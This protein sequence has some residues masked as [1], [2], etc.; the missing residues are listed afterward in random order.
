[1]GRW[2][3]LLL[4]C[5]CAD[6]DHPSTVKDLRVLALAAEPSEV[7]LDVAAGGAVPPIT[8]TALVVDPLGAGRPLGFAVRACANDPRAPTAPGTGSEASGNYPAGGAR[9]TVGS[10]RCPAESATSWTLPPAV[11]PGP[12]GF[13][14]TIQ[15]SAAQLR[16]AFETDLFLGPLGQPHGGFDLGLPITVELAVEA[17]T[18]RVV[19]IKRVLFWREQLA[20]QQRPNRNPV[21]GELRG[22]TDRD[23]V[24]LAPTSPSEPLAPE[25]ARTVFTDQKLWIEPAGAEAEP[26]VTTVVDRFTDQTHPHQVPAETLRYQFF[27]TAGKFEPWETTSELPFGA[28]PASRIP[29]EGQY[30]PPAADSLVADATGRRTREVTIWIVARDERGGASWTKRRLLVTAR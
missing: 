28:T 3:A 2:L 25:T 20:D 8:L 15:L 11:T 9:S 27:A 24:T 13:T 7:I 1:M 4:V 12:D 23:P 14:F 16:A 26:Y 22:Y 21:I 6:F 29:T 17:G 18:E 5:G 10:A 30:Q 19:A